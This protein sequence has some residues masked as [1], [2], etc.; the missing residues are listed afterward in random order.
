MSPPEVERFAL[1]AKSYCELLEHLDEIASI[2]ERWRRLAK[3]LAEL[4]AGVLDLPEVVHTDRLHDEPDV[5]APKLDLGDLDFY[6]VVIDPFDLVDDRRPP[7]GQVTEDLADI[8]RDLQGGLALWRR[9]APEDVNDAVESWKLLFKVHWGHR[10]TGAL[11]ALACALADGSGKPKLG[12]T[13][14]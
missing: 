8:Y 3:A 9:G 7:I 4:I 13:A 14:P 12:P 2:S 11:R 1:A 6:A 5:A 10:A